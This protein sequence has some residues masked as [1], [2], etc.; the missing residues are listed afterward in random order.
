MK[1]AKKTLCFLVILF[2]VQS[3]SP[4]YFERLSAVEGNLKTKGGYNS[5]LALEYLEF[6]RNL[7][8]IKN[9]RD[10]EHFAKKGLQSSDGYNVVPENPI[11]WDADKLQVAELI[12]MQKRLE[13]SLNTTQIKFYLPIQMAHLT[14]LYDCWVSRES[15]PVF[16]VSDLTICKSRFYKLLD[17][18]EYYI[19]DSKRDTT[20]KIKITEPEFERF[21]VVFDLNNYKLNEQAQRDMTKILKYLRTLEGDYKIL[22][23]GNADR[24]GSELYN[25]GLSSQRADIVLDYLVKNGVIKDFVETRSIG[26]DFPD[27]I[28]KDGV[29]QQFNRNVGIYVLKGN[30]SFA[31]FPLP[32]VKNYIYRKEIEKA[33]KERGLE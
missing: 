13:T 29:Q 19:E 32:L 15:K 27:L 5:Y 2:F 4:S 25:E 8:S 26:E 16:R 31:D 20:P 23:V 14:Y 1:L 12:L 3:C 7:L 11:K 22:V 21:E 30:R 24:L 33:R 17:E 18:V 6:S 10:A 9:E 28:T